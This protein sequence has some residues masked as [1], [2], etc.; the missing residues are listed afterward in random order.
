MIE[1]AAAGISL[2]PVARGFRARVE[3][4]IGGDTTAA[5]RT[6]G[7]TLGRSMASSAAGALRAGLGIGVVGAVGGFLKSS[8]SSIADFEGTLNEMAAVADVPAS[9][10]Q[11]LSDLAMQ[12]GRD[13]VFSAQD[14]AGNVTLHLGSTGGILPVRTWSTSGPLTL[15][16]PGCANTTTA[17]FDV[18]NTGGHGTPG[19]WRCLVDAMNGALLYR[20]NEV[21]TERPVSEDSGADVTLTGTISMSPVL[22]TQV[23]GMRN[24]HMTIGGQAFVTDPNGFI[25]SGHAGPVNFTAP[26]SGDWSVVSTANVT[27]SL[28]GQLVEGANDVT[29]DN[30][31]TIQERSA[32]FHVNNI[33]DHMK[34]VLP[35]FTGMDSP[36]PTNV[37]LT[38]DNCNAFYDG[39]SINFYAEANDCY[40]MALIA[41]V[42]YHEYG[43][44][45]NHTF[46]AAGGNT[47]NNG[48]MDEGYADVWGISLTLDPVLALG[49]TISNP[50]SY[51][52]RYD[53]NKKVYPVD[54]TGE[55]HADG[56]I[57]AGAWW[58]TYLQLGNDM[59]QTMALFAEA[60]AGYQATAVDG[61]EG[62]AFR[63]VLID[64]LQADGG[65]DGLGRKALVHEAGAG[66]RHVQEGDAEALAGRQV[67]EVLQQLF[68]CRC[69]DGFGVELHAFT[70]EFAVPQPH[71][72]TIRSRRRDFQHRRQTFAFDN[73]RM[74]TRGGERVIQPG[75]DRAAIVQNLTGLAVH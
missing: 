17:K 58:D 64:A 6:A 1:V 32:Y 66:V 72:Q 36:L 51:I 35:S 13:T 22:P 59:P 40:S 31:A 24:L 11:G 43:H 49:Y 42:P 47:Y 65:T 74:V 50:Q 44:G 56:E 4:E 62:P 15:V 45:I 52:R 20:K 33:H 34:A 68:A 30:N 2:M 5:G 67:E 25:A 3:R 7:T 38:T 23:E 29:F 16:K 37:D 73:Q 18:V 9:K 39:A 41:D 46:Y 14:A 48:A 60:Y 54:I 12:M 53:I 19:R 21:L 55:P 28:T 57:I 10:I 71:N 69:H 8:I 27:P 61:Q 75:K 70:D 63:Q 26:L